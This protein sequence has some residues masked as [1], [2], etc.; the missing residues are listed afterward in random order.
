MEVNVLNVTKI[1]VLAFIFVVIFNGCATIFKG[2][3]EEVSFASEPSD[4][5]VYINGSHIGKTPVQVKLKTKDNYTIEFKK[6]G[7]EPRTHIMTNSVGGGWVVLDILGGLIA[8][9]V[10][11]ATGN[12][13][14]FDQ[15]FIKITLEPNQGGSK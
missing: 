7:F 1:A 4:A 14:S 3:T 10:D 12:W 11:A 15:T 6:D 5:K 9:G 13:Y 2:S 8:L